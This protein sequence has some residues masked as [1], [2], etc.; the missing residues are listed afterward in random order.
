MKDIMREEL[1]KRL[2]KRKKEISYELDSMFSNY[3]S[4][5]LK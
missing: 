1:R 2:P 4:F 5:P 3:K